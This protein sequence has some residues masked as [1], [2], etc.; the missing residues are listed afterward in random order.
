MSYTARL[1]RLTSDA[2]LDTVREL[3]SPIG[4]VLVA[5]LLRPVLGSELV[6]GTPHIATTILIWMLFAAA[7]NLLFGYVG[8]LS[9]G[10]AIFLGT[11]VYVTAIGLS[12]F[13]LPF[14]LMTVVAIV[15]SGAIAYGI[16]RIIVRYGEIYFA[17]LTLAFAMG[18]HFIVNSNPYGLTGG[19]DGLRS[20]TTPDWIG[21][22]RGQ[23]VIDVPWFA[24]LLGAFGL[25]PS[26]YYFVAL[27]FVVAM[28]LLW[29]I[30]RSPFGRTLVAIRDN[31]E[32]AR[33]MGISV[34]R[35]KV[36]AFTVSG[37]FSALAG[38]LL[39]LS[40]YGAAIENFSPE[41]SA[42]VLLMT[43]FGG[44]NFFFG[45]LVGALSW[46]GVQEY[47]QSF[48]T[49]GLPVVG[50]IEVSGVLGYW[51]FFFGLAFVVVI[52]L[53]PRNGVWGFVRDAVLNGIDAIRQRGSND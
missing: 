37:A 28:V 5:F 20:G 32:L 13:G 50:A 14:S 15:A 9:F 3:K 21:S 53:S 41:T 1:K 43:I 16:C 48:E 24:D 39:M 22:F 18:V 47:L 4:I 45:P 6:L 27:V 7:F 33:A 23:R 46:F 25:E 11:G 42:E 10:H 35:Y 40:N 2:D 36:W 44:A 30:I 49:L 19:S 38:A 51:R 12:E 34:N 29:Q 17:M 52:L 26:Y 8:L 31:E